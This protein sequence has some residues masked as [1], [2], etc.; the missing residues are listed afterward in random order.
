MR[1]YIEQ[2][3]AATCVIRVPALGAKLTVGEEN[4][5]QRQQGDLDRQS[6]SRPRGAAADKRRSGGESVGGD[7]RKLA[8]QGVGRAQ[9]KNRM[10]PRGD[11]QREHR[12]GARAVP[13]E[14]R[15]GL[16]RGPAADAQVHR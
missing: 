2:T 5:G 11:L 9:G 7:L 12:Q 13:E 16:Y 4:G 1:T 6:R 3:A 8:R 15:Q 14:G 10:A